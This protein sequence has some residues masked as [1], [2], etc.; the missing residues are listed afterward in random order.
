MGARFLLDTPAALPPWNPL[1]TPTVL[2]AS[3]YMCSILVGSSQPQVAYKL[4]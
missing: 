1:L 2:D 3:K 4:G